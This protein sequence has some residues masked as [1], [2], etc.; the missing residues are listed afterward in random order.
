MI[1][2]VMTTTPKLIVDLFHPFLLQTIP[3]GEVLDSVKKHYGREIGGIVYPFWTDLGATTGGLKFPGAPADQLKGTSFADVASYCREKGLELWARANLNIDFME[4][5]RLNVVSFLSQRA[6]ICCPM[7]PL[8]QK[9]VEMGIQEITA[10]LP[11]DDLKVWKGTVISVQDLWGSSASEGKINPTCF[12]AYCTAALQENGFDVDSLRKNPDAWRLLLKDAGGGLSFFS[13]FSSVDGPED[14]VTFSDEAGFYAQ[15]LKLKI[16]QAEKENRIEFA[17]AERERLRRLGVVIHGYVQ[18]FNS[19]TTK[20]LS[21]YSKIFARCSANKDHRVAIICDNQTYDWNSRVFLKELEKIDGVSETWMEWASEQSSD[22]PG[23][24]RQIL[25]RRG[26]YAID[27]F[28]E[29]ID[30]RESKKLKFLTGVNDSYRD[31]RIRQI[32]SNVEHSLY[33]SEQQI[34]FDSMLE[35]D[36]CIGQVVP[37]LTTENLP[38]LV[39]KLGLH[40][41]DKSDGEMA[42]NPAEIQGLLQRLMLDSTSE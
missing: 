36:G 18:A 32:L 14:L 27:S 35:D 4:S 38:A 30:S 28:F 42:F 22:P 13:A 3:L 10:T 15:E 19:A 31:H 29:I 2:F 24:S 12:C 21:R 37:G 11:T 25:C 8:T 1:E 33:G 6:S 17:N 34:V 20:M 41:G 9:V 23:S 26:F 7:N 40:S 16:A 5:S 39:R